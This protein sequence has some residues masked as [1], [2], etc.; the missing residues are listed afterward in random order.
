MKV[1]ALTVRESPL[2][3]NVAVLSCTA[4]HPPP[5]P[6]AP[7]EAVGLKV[8]PREYRVELTVAQLAA[9]TTR[10]R[11]LLNLPPT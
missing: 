4:I 10:L 5:P 11:R 6:H 3:P 9:L 7:S 1:T 8:G 2:N